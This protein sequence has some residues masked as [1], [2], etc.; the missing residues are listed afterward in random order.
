VPLGLLSG[1]LIAA[2]VIFILFREI[3]LRYQILA[4]T[5]FSTTTPSTGLLRNCP[6][7]FH[8]N[9]ISSYS[10]NRTA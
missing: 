1:D 7:P 6:I 10:A 9:I 5:C 2:S 8:Q 4:L 3:V